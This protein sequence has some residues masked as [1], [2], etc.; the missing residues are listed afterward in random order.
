MHAE[1]L[2]AIRRSAAIP[3]MP[4]VATRCFEITQDPHCDYDALVGLLSTDAGI[5]AEILR[6]SNSPLFG[7]ARKVTSLKQAVGLLGLRRLRDLVLTRYLVQRLDDSKD[8][9]LDLAYFWRRSLTTAVIAARLSDVIAPAERDQAF[10]A[11]LLA[12]VGVVVLLRALPSRYRPIAEHYRPLGGEGWIAEEQRL[13]GVGHAE[14]SAVVLE[15][16]RLPE[17]LVNAVRLHHAP[18]SSDVLAP[19]VGAASTVARVLC[20][21]QDAATAADECAAACE[22]VGLG[23]DALA[24]CL[25]EIEGDVKSL[26]EMLRIEIVANRIFHLIAE[27]IANRVAVG[28]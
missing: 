7:V 6:L 1:T 3:S 26:A 12:D 17:S 23:L 22:S 13:L 24:R 28:A 11:G 4:L 5:A 21:A 14:V 18:A 15:E 9:A 27:Q 25:P 19:I 10:M 2:E 20:E 8:D 16:W